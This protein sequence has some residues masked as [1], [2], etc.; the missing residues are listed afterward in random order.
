MSDRFHVFKRSGK[1]LVSRRPRNRTFRTPSYYFLPSAAG[2]FTVTGIAVLFRV[3]L[4]GAATSYL[5]P[6]NAAPL[7]VGLLVSTGSYAVTGNAA[8]FSLTWV[9]S[10]G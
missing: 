6:G 8:L 4:V 9:L 1:V 2:S 10:A 3:N 5:I 7:T